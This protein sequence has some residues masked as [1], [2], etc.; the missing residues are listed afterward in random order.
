M[1]NPSSS[2]ATTSQVGFENPVEEIDQ[3]EIWREVAQLEQPAPV[4]PANPAP[5]LIHY[6]PGEFEVP[7]IIQASRENSLFRRL[8][9][10]IFEQSIFVT[11][12]EIEDVQKSLRSAPSH[13]DYV[14][15]LDFWCSN[16]RIQE[17]RHD[18]ANHLKRLLSEEA[19]QN[20][21]LAELIN[22]N[23]LGNCFIKL[24]SAIYDFIEGDSQ[25]KL[26]LPYRQE[27]SLETKLLR[28]IKNDL[29]NEG[30]VSF[31]FDQFLKYLYSLFG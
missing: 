31:T 2:R 11:S 22:S 20:P 6:V 21:E 19:S 14:R 27:I 8:R 7:P 5:G 9:K 4:V 12:D 10:L 25:E 17:Q 1:A 23:N 15:L 18:C 13:G 26:E 29:I 3:D 24:D 28:K 30:D 16:A